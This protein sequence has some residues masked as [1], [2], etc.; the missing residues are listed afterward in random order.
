MIENYSNS[1]HTIYHGD[2]VNILAS[3]HIPIGSIDLIFIDPPYNIGKNFNGL[4]DKWPSEEKYFEW[5]TNWLDLCIATLK[6][7]GSLYLMCATQYFAQF[8]LLLQQRL[9]ILSRII[10][11]YDSSGKQ[12]KHYFGSLWE[13]IFHCVVDPKKYTFN[14]EDIMVEAKTGSQRKLIDYRKKVPEQYGTKKVPGNAWYFPR[15]R[16]RMA[17]YENHPTQKPI[18]LLKRIIAASSNPGDIILDPFAGTFTS[19]R[20][21]ANLHR[22]SIS[23]EID[24][25]YTK[26]GLRRLQIATHY[27]SEILQQPVKTYQKNK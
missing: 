24:E 15:V 11:H 14:T 13:P 22:K 8:D 5:V 23:I 21:A 12:A 9:T 7:T 19:G 18:A 6:P 20:A 26:I 4:Q 25:Q 3:G 16:Y 2:A 10:W 27:G 1:K 17:E